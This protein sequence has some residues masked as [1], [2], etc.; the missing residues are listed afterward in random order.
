MRPTL[1]ILVLFAL[2]CG[3]AA[4]PTRPPSGPTTT[5][6]RVL[7][8]DS[9]LARQAGDAV[10]VR[11][12]GV[13]APE[14]GE[15]HADRSRQAL[16][17]RLAAGEVAVQATE[18][19]RF[20]RLLGTVTVDGEDVGLAL[21]SAGAALALDVDHPGRAAY[22]AAEEEAFA[23]GIGLW[24]REACGPATTGLAITAVAAD[25]PGRDE[26]A[27][28][29]EWVDIANE[30]PGTVDLGGWTL[31]DESSTHRYRFPDD[32]VIESGATLR[33]IVGC[34]TDDGATA[35]WC[36]DGPVWNNG[37]DA[38]LLLDASGNVAARL[39]Y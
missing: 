30:G 19:D 26:E 31:R 6:G 12:L 7:D 2:A 39:R 10:E 4:A 38:A 8:G 24:Q 18:T 23:T 33:V 21:V 5:V 27:L 32:R 36:S 20:G 14:R 25:P 16:A 13:N 37:G 3:D 17:D 11:L 29:G 1:A 9:F 34:G 28:D 22:L 35:H 15:C